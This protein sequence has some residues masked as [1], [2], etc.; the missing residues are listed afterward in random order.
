MAHVLFWFH[1]LQFRFFF[2]FHSLPVP[3]ANT[4]NCEVQ[5]Y[6]NRASKRELFKTLADNRPDLAVSLNQR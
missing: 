6:T 5:R 1:L 3:G 4:Q 2:L